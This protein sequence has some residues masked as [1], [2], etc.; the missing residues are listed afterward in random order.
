MNFITY[1]PNYLINIK[2]KKILEAIKLDQE[3]EKY[4]KENKK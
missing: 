2:D 4:E 3:L 1:L